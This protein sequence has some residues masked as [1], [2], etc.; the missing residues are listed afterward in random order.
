MVTVRPSGTE[1]KI[2]YYVLARTLVGAEGLAAAKKASAAK[3]DAILADIRKA[4][5]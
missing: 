1:P 3:V 5:G 2:K 4:I